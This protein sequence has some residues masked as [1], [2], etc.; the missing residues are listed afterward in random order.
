MSAWHAVVDSPS[1]R[2]FTKRGPGR[3]IV[4]SR[5]FRRAMVER[6]RIIGGRAAR[7]SPGL[8]ADAH[9]FCFFV[10]HNKSGT[11]LLGGLLDAHPQI[12]LADEAD[13]LQYVVAGFE[14]D[15]LFHVLLRSSRTEARKGRVT[16]RRLEPYSYFVAGQSQGRCARPLVVGDST[17]GTSTRRLGHQPELVDQLYSLGTRVK[18]IQVVRNPFDPITLMMI[19]GGRTFDDA[20]GHY[21][22]ACRTLEA[23][24]ARVP[25]DDLLP[26]RYEDVVADPSAALR[27][28]CAFLGVEPSDEYVHACVRVVRSVP[29]HSRERIDW[30]R[31]RIDEVERRSAPFAFLDGYA[32]AS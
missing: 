18:V 8:F 26:V 23:I 10:G 12:V 22:D 16:A 31:A 9:T 30:P 32:H 17:S 7:E 25:D 24:R 2:W 13:A 3:P 1:F 15:A 19:R 5:T 28:T 6:N 20:I 21:F 4:R 14:R 11:S 29:D 27:R